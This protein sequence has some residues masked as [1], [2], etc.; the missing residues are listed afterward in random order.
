MVEDPL[1]L[2]YLARACDIYYKDKSVAVNYYS[3]Y[4]RS[5]EPTEEY[6]QLAKDRRQH[7]REQMHQGK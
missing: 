5:S 4:I 3:K 6:K 1:V 2:F 7:L